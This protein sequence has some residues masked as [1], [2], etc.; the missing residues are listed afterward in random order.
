MKN[1]LIS[2]IILY[3][4]VG[5]SQDCLSDTVRY[6][7]YSDLQELN[8]QS[9]EYEKFTKAKE[10][11]LQVT[12]ISKKK[13]IKFVDRLNNYN[14]TF[15]ILGCLMSKDVLSYECIDQDNERRCS[16]SF[17]ATNTSYELT[18]SYLVAPI[19]YKVSRV[20]NTN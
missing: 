17:G 6:S 14:K 4:R 3:F 10:T 8:T 7:H 13:V 9:G 19:V 18:V 1:I 16:L 15:T 5:Y 2:L 20:K 12:I 11:S